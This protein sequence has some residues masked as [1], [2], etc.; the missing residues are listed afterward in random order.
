MWAGLAKFWPTPF[1][2]ELTHPPGVL[3]AH[4]GVAELSQHLFEVRRRRAAAC[5]LLHAQTSAV[6]VHCVCSMA[7]CSSHCTAPLSACGEHICT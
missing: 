6:Y 5:G 7:R 3:V 4:T 2:A 1:A